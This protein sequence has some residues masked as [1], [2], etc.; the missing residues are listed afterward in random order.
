MAVALAVHGGYLTS[1]LH[2]SSSS[3]PK[4]AA[5]IKPSPTR[6]PPISI[7]TDPVHVD[8]H[9]L[10]ALYAICN[11]SGHRFPTI[12]AAGRVDPVDPVKLRTALSHSAVVVSAFTKPEFV[13]TQSSTSLEV[14]SFIGIGGNWIRKVSPVT[15][16][17]GRLIGFGRAVSDMGFTASIY[18]VMVSAHLCLA[19]LDPSYIN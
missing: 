11:H 4:I 8:L 2:S 1:K 14:T 16:E 5:G 17:N 7:S 18:D 6:R 9:H 13:T 15:P 19:C 12:D 3:P 10:R